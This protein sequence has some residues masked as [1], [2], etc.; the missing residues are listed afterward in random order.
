MRLIFL[1]Q[2]TFNQKDIS[3]APW[4]HFY[5]EV[6]KHLTVITVMHKWSYRTVVHVWGMTVIFIRCKTI[7]RTYK[8]SAV[9]SDG[10]IICC[11]YFCTL[12][13]PEVIC[14]A[15]CHPASFDLKHS[16]HR[17]TDWRDAV[18][19]GSGL[20]VC[21][22]VSGLILVLKARMTSFWA[23]F[24]CKKVF[25]ISALTVGLIHRSADIM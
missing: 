16:S 5:T 1:F 23:S 14:P 22:E 20:P 11:L 12:H 9:T 4:F 25:K 13:P 15:Y 7:F 2:E 17:V 8:S 10:G 18:G 3:L 24:C 21:L 19:P 6:P